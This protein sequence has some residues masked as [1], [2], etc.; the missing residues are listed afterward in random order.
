MIEKTLIKTNKLFV[1]DVCYCLR[2]DIYRG[3]WGDEYNYAD[4]IIKDEDDTVI[5]VIGSTAY[6]DGSYTSDKDIEYSVDA[7]VIGVSNLDY[8]DEAYVTLE[9]LGTVVDV[10]SGKAAVFFECDEGDFFIKIID[11]DS[12]EILYDDVIPTKSESTEEKY[13]WYEDDEEYDYF[14]NDDDDDYKDEEDEDY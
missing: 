13:G 11:V 5:S 3:I 9:K 10:P 12:E 8:S 6:G 4:G 1:G 2:D 14:N 7:G